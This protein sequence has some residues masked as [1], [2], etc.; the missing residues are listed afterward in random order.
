[1][2][3]ENHPHHSYGVTVQNKNKFTDIENMLYFMLG[4]IRLAN[5]TLV[6]LIKFKTNSHYS[7]VNFVNRNQVHYSLYKV[8]REKSVKN[9]EATLRMKS[10][11]K[12]QFRA[13]LFD[14]YKSFVQLVFVHNIF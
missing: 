9:H 13:P 2:I 10:Y 8:Y 1:M 5:S 6:N 14:K 12:N 7:N 3:A 4:V 11:V